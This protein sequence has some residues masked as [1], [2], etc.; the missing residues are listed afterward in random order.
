MAGSRVYKCGLCH[1]RALSAR[2]I[3]RHIISTRHFPKKRAP[4]I[5]RKLREK[6]DNIPLVSSVV[7]DTTNKTIRQK[8]RKKLIKNNTLTNDPQFL[9]NQSE[10]LIIKNTSPILP[11]HKTY[12]LRLIDNF[13]LMVVGPS[14]CGKT[15]WIVDFFKNLNS[16]TRKPPTKIVYIFSI[17]QQETYGVLMGNMVHLF[18]QD[19]KNLAENLEAKLADLGWTGEKILI[20]FDDLIRSPN[21]AWIS[22]LFTVFGRHNDYSVIFLAQRYYNKTEDWKQITGNNDYLVYFKNPGNKTEI[23]NISR[24]MMGGQ[25]IAKMYEAATDDEAFSYLFMN[26]TQQ[27]D[28][29]VRYLTNLFDASGKVTAFVQKRLLT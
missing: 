29:K 25:M 1:Y 24:K 22:S 3:R 10:K 2:E 17:W 18:F 15:W 28:E 5:A 9:P 26:N 16:F 21:V 19:R 6:G 13:K 14:R 12:D 11:H 23:Q 27:C 20:V 4:M 8:Q 7:A